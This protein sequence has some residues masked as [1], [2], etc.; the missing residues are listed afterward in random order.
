MPIGFGLGLPRLSKAHAVVLDHKFH[1]LIR[2]I[3]SNVNVCGLRVRLDVVQRLLQDAIQR[4]TGRHEQHR[5]H[6]R[7]NF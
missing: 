5:V 6:S 2:V 1:A 3:Q 4:V 7:R